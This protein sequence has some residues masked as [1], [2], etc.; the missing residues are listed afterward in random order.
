MCINEP[1]G[2]PSALAEKIPEKRKNL[3]KY[4]IFF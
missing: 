3:Q 4:Y 1:Q 2:K